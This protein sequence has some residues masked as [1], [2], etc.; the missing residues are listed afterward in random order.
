MAQRVKGQDALIRLVS[1]GNL[2]SEITAI[3]N[4]EATVDLQIL[5]EGYLGETTDRY[6]EIMKGITGKLDIHWETPQVLQLAIDVLDRAKRREPGTRIDAYALISFPSLGAAKQIQ[7][8]NLFFGNMPLP[9]IANRSAYLKTTL[10]W[11][12]GDLSVI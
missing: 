12:C 5:E 3:T 1:K 7:F 6:D 10:N 2:Q 8:P 4:F 9:N 11:K